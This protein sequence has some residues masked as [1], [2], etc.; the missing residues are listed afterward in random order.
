M[1]LHVVGIACVVLSSN[2][3]AAPGY[4]Q[5]TGEVVEVTDTTIVIKKGEE[6]WHLFRD[7]STQATGD[8]KVGAKVTIDYKMMA[9]SAEIK[10]KAA[11]GA[12]KKK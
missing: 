2:L 7:A 12:P 4:Y 11:S 9:T 10:E 5:V 1:I 8:L 3:L 6:K